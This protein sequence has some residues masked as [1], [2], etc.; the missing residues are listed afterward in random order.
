MVLAAATA[1]ATT[2]TA[3]ASWFEIYVRAHGGFEYLDMTALD[4][5]GLLD[6]DSYDPRTASTDLQQRIDNLTQNY[7]GEGWV[8]GGQAGLLL[9]EFLDVGIDFRQ[10][11][12]YFENSEGKHTQACLNLLLHFVDLPD[13][14]EDEGSLFDP[15]IGL[16]FGYSYLTTQIPGLDPAGPGG[17]SATSNQ[18]RTSNG[19]I[20]RVMAALDIRFLTWMS[21]GISADFGFLYFAGDNDKSAWG[22]NTDIMLRLSFH[23]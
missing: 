6:P 11:G 17:L 7:K 8:V 23:I 4:A 18:E 22:F 1:L 5:S 2:S 21:A 13:D 3:E 16:G 10:A 20:G 15:S 19:F 14:E 9:F 12:I